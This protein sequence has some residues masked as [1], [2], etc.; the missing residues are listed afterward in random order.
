MSKNK[1]EFNFS[2]DYAKSIANISTKV[3]RTRKN[4]TSCVIRSESKCWLKSSMN[5]L[6][7]SSQIPFYFL[8][9]R[10]TTGRI[11]AG[12]HYLSQYFQKNEIQPFFGE[13]SKQQPFKFR[14]GSWNTKAKGDPNELTNLF[15]SCKI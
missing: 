7:F 3:F 12:L 1:M 13:Y 11:R 5:I 8:L 4:D 10:R 2:K 14:D 15:K 6:N 9:L